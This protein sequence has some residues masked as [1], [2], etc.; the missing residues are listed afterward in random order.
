[1]LEV[2]DV[3]SSIYDIIMPKNG[4][5]LKHINIQLEKTLKRK[6]KI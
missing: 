1:M 5:N 6:I 3:E 4:M 2:Y